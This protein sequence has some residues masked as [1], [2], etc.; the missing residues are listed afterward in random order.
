MAGRSSVFHFSSAASAA[1][2]MALPDMKVRR[3]AEA[4][5]GLPIVAESEVTIVTFSNGTPTAP[6]ANCAM[7]VCVPC[8][9]SAPAC[10]TT[11]CSISVLPCSST[12]AQEFSW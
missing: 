10:Q 9:T 1:P 11:T 4:L 8:P 3:E 12:R 6:A 5:P 2:L 7:T